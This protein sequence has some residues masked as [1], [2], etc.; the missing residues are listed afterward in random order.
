MARVGKR[1]LNG[2]TMTDL[3][4]ELVGDLEVLARRLREGDAV[5]VRATIAGFDDY[6]RP[7]VELGIRDPEEYPTGGG[8]AAFVVD[9]EDVVK[10]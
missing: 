3:Q 2:K 1:R 4:A 9:R 8:L 10:R 6:G 7:I 5:Y